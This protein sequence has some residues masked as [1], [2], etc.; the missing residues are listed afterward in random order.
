MTTVSSSNEKTNLVLIGM[1]GSGKS[2]LGK[3]LADDLSI[4]FL[5]TDRLI[6]QKESQPIQ[7]I[8]DKSG[9]NYLKSLEQSV[10]CDLSVKRHL[11]ATGGSAVLS[12]P[13]MRHL[14]S[15]GKI[16]YLKIKLSTLLARVE[17]SQT[18]G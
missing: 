3:R 5:D 2:T 11:L 6:E 12:D 17:N 8:A 9:I 14:S 10:L 1:P 7:A 16:I 18:R 13:A 15:I 4:E